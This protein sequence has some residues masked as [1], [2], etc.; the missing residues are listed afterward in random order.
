MAE[1]EGNGLIIKEGDNIEVLDDSE[2]G[3]CIVL[4]GLHVGMHVYGGGGGE[5]QFGGLVLI[6][7]QCDECII[8]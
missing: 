6:C 1:Y 8:G 3:K 7:T 2:N 5:R 4:R